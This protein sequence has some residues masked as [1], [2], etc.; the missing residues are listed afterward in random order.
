M[1]PI[2]LKSQMKMLPYNLNHIIVN[3][4]RR[5]GIEK[6][7]FNIYFFNYISLNSKLRNKS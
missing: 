7:V 3:R 2:S 6:Q 1:T 4:D 5:S